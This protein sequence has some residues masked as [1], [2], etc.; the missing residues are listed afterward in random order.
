MVPKICS[1]PECNT[2]GPLSRGWCKMHYA[3]WVR[4][5][6]VGTA[7]KQVS[8]VSW[9]GVTCKVDGCA[10]QV[11]SIGY[12]LP[13]YK[14]FKRWGDATI[15]YPRS[16]PIDR[17]QGHIENSTGSQC[18]VWTAAIGNHGYGI[19]HPRK[20]ETV[21][22]HRY[23]YEAEYGPIPDGLHI[24]HLCR[25]R[26]CVNPSHLEAVEPIENSR[27]GLSHRLLNGMD[28]SCINGHKYTLENTYVNP[29]KKNDIRCRRCAANRD[30]NRKKVA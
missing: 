6:E 26:K 7:E 22:A 10:S 15:R 11:R 14:R 25:N 12:C 9:A 30:L 28:D 20:A 4:H 21:L 13:H 2:S 29:N 1:V 3:R 24:D 8:V 5:G 17:F 19:F 16:N 18:L 27:R 23:A